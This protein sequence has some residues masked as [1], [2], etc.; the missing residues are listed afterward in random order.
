M[1]YAHW[2]TKKTYHDYYALLEF[3]GMKV[4]EDPRPDGEFWYSKNRTKEYVHTTW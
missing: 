1:L 2:I 4:G 3:I